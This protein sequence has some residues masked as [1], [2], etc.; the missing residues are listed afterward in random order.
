M[1]KLID[2]SCFVLGILIFL[3]SIFVLNLSCMM[4]AGE[5][6]KTAQSIAMVLALINSAVLWW[7][8][9]ELAIN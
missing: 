9:Y 1:R 3:P 4:G 6:S 8:I 2:W 5:G 7:M